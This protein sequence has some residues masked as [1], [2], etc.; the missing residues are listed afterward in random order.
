MFRLKTGFWWLVVKAIKLAS[1]VLPMQMP[2]L[3]SG[4]GASR[5][6]T[7]FVGRGGFNHVLLVTDK[8]LTEIGLYQPMVQMLEQAG[9][10][11]SVFDEV[12][13]DPTDEQI[14]RGAERFK[15]L[16]CDAVI[17]VGGGSPMDAAKMIAVLPFL[18]KPV[19]KCSGLLRIRRKG[20]PLFLV[21]TTAGTG[22]E[23]TIAAVVTVAGSGK[24]LPVADP[25]LLPE[26]AALDPELMT[27]LPPA[28]TAASGY[29]ALTHAVEAY[30]STNAT[31]STDRY[32]LSAA[33]LIWQNLPVCMSTP[34]DLGAR[35]AMAMASCYAGIAFTKSGLG[36]THGIAHQLGAFYHV[37]HGVANAMVL[38]HV[39]RFSLP[40]CASRLEELARHCGIGE[41]GQGDLEL[42]REFI[43]KLE[44]LRESLGLPGK[45][46]QL[47]QRDY[48]VIT[49]RAFAESHMLYAVPRY[50]QV[51]DCYAVLRQL[52]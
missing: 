39:L 40:N 27:G 42:A 4:P 33:R 36:Y 15:S 16:G 46:E 52:A 22:S 7:A 14:T 3:Y 25:V 32:A 26:A 19:N 50:M 35:E 8:A 28:V 9:V 34:G 41:P 48:G 10:R 6:L 23:V 47:S 44:Q 13:P 21:P 51:E 24:K 20:A 45:C 12:T 18:N 37:P 5:Q 38:P 2:A 1:Y 43:D 11:V 31:S 30:I 29:D 49:Q 17:G